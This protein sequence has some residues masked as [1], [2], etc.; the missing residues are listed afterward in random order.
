LFSPFVS[1]LI[2]LKMAR[3]EN[4]DNVVNSKEFIL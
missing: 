2:Y 1:F 4:M 3:G